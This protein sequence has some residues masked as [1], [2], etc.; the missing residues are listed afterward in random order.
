[1]PSK[2]LSEEELGLMLHLVKRYAETDLEQFEILKFD[3]EYG[4]VNLSISL[5]QNNPD[6]GYIDVTDLIEK[7][8]SNNE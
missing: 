2:K 6:D 8:N 7:Y 3:T 4:K 5:G 1:M